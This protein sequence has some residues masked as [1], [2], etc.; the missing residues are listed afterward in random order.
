MYLTGLTK[1]FISSSRWRRII[2]LACGIPRA[3]A[4]ASEPNDVSK[5]TMPPCTPL[6]TRL[7]EYS[8]NHDD[9]NKIPVHTIQSEFFGT[10]SNSNFNHH[11]V[12]GIGRP[13]GKRPN[14][15]SDLKSSTGCLFIGANV[16][17]CKHSVVPTE[18][19]GNWLFAILATN[20]LSK[21]N[22]LSKQTSK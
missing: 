12:H 18:H 15:T 20:I 19:G 11:K 22:T 1:A 10:F 13:W 14:S 5:T 21:R 4:M 7:S 3:V 16:H 2:P 8:Y 9:T 17:H 6:S